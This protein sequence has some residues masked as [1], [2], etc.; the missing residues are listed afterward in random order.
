VEGFDFKLNLSDTP[1]ESGVRVLEP[2][3]DDRGR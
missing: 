1:F 3:G 2:D